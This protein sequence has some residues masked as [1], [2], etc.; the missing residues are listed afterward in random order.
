MPMAVI[1]DKSHRYGLKRKSTA[2]GASTRSGVP[3]IRT[4]VAVTDPLHENPCLGHDTNPIVMVQTHL[5][6]ILQLHFSC[7]ATRFQLQWQ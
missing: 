3:T 4:K 6:L 2:T 7:K 5:Y 1:I